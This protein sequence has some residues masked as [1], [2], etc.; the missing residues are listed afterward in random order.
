M[1]RDLREYAKQTNFRLI[2]GG[3]LILFIVGDG[4]IYVI[5]GKEAAITGLICLSIGLTPLILIWLALT[6][7]G[8]IASRANSD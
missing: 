2:V 3:L 1:T 7:I 5:Y 6:L 8:Y 4:L